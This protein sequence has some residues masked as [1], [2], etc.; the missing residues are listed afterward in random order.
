MR[1]LRHLHA[2][3]MC[4]AA[5]EAAVVVEEIPFAVEFYDGMVVGP[6]DDGIQDYTLVGE[7]PAGMRIRRGIE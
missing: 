1:K 3:Q 2:P 5:G 4:L 7:W 6:A